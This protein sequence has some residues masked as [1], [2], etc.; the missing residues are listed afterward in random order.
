MAWNADVSLPSL[1]R[2]RG[3]PLIQRLDGRAVVARAPCSS[4]ATPTTRST[5]STPISAC[6]SNRL[7]MS[8]TR[9]LPYRC[10]SADA[11]RPAFRTVASSWLATIRIGRHAL[12]RVEHG[13]LGAGHVEHGVAVVR[14]PR[15]AAASQSAAGPSAPTGPL[16][17]GQQVHAGRLASARRGSRRT[18]R[19]AGACSPS[20]RRPRTAARRR[21]R[22]PRRRRTGGSPSAASARRST[23]APAP[24][25]R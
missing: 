10:R 7:T 12:Q 14:R 9:S 1:S 2:A 16:R 13:S 22:P 6:L 20:R 24:S 11:I 23:A 25:R 15:T 19:R 8:F 18:P 17:R 5:S 3:R 21:G 4:P